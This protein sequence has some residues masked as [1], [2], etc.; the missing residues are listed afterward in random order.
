MSDPDSNALVI[1][2]SPIR[3]TDTVTV[4]ALIADAGGPARF[5][6]EEFLYGQIRNPG[7]RKA[8]LRALGQFSAWCVTH[9]LEL[10]RVTPADVARYLDALPVAVPTRK[11]H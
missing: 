8:Y 6:Y 5:A 1:Q 2:S 9:G 11:L 3:I 4:P 7:T 10:T